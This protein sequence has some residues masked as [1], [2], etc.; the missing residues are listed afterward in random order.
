[1]SSG[2]TAIIVKKV[3]ENSGYCFRSIHLVRSA[4]LVIELYAKF[5]GAECSQ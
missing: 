5:G 4:A 2:Y 1:M 3:T